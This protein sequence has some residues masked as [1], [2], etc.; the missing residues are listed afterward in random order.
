L[1]SRND[2]NGL[3]VFFTGSLVV[4]MARSSLERCVV[5]L[6]AGHQ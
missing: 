3:A 4:V 2:R 6:G 5:V 1:R